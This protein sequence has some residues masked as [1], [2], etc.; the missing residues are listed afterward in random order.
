[1]FIVNGG[2]PR[3]GTVLVGEIIRALL[4]RRGLEVLRYNPQERRHLP[5][6][7]N[8]ISEAP[9]NATT[10][11]HTHLIDQTCLDAL[12]ARDDAVVFWN[13][14][15]PRDALVSLIRLHDM[16]LEQA[17][18][19]MEVYL[20][21]ADLP[22]RW[23]KA[24][25]IR[26]ERL[27]A[28]VDQHVLGIANTLGYEAQPSEIASIREATTPDAHAK[29]MRKLQKGTVDETRHIRTLYRDMREDKETLINDRHLQSGQHGRW[30]TE[31]SPE[32]A[33]IVNERLGRWI[34]GYGYDL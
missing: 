34:E 19:S 2:I 6:F 15:D 30:K 24:L 20:T 9:V 11:V 27:V 14:R 26:Y 21:A 29:I 4:H 32:D 22:K 8:K 1:M 33:Q 16:P 25:G 31:L 13:H 23:G 17:L 10:L 5:E 18:L 12:T 3:S 7:A 28:N